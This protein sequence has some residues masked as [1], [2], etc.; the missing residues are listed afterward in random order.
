MPAL[1]VSEEVVPT[2]G[3]TICPRGGLLS[4]PLAV[5]EERG[6]LMDIAPARAPCCTETG[7]RRL[8]NQGLRVDFPSCPL[9]LALALLF[10]SI[11]NKPRSVLGHI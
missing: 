9:P 1:T 7:T 10:H 8:R 3:P 2:Q 4:A 11:R 5:T 6:V